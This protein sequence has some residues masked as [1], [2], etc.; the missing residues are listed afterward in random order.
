MLL[1]VEYDEHFME[2]LC[3]PDAKITCTNMNMNMN[4]VSADNLHRI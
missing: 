1:A 3:K 2:L 4:A